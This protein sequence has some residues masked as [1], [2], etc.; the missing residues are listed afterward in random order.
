MSTVGESY[1]VLTSFYLNGLS[2]NLSEWSWSMV[3]KWCV[4]F[5]KTIASI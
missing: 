4:G 2:F 3:W 1:V 5:Y